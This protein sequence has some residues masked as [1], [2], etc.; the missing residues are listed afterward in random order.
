MKKKKGFTLVELLAVIV[1]LAIILVIAVPQ[2]MDTIDSARSAS[3]ESSAKMVAAQVENQHTVS[4]TLGTNFSSSG[5]CTTAKWAGL[6]DKDYESCTYSID[7]N[8]KASVTLVGKGK[9][10][11]KS[12]CDGTRTSAKVT[13]GECATAESC[14]TFDSSTGTITGYDISCGTDVVIP[15]KIGGVSVTVIGK[16]AFL[17]E[18]ITSVVL[19]DTISEIGI[20]AF[21]SNHITHLTIPSSVTEIRSDAFYGNPLESVNLGNASIIIGNCAFAINY[22]DD[23]SNI[24]VHNIPESYTCVD[25]RPQ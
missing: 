22:E 11:G 9:F 1:I 21:D 5:D 4:Q 19:P 3:L 14:F 15:S 8:G 10:D 13:E 7:S 20:A 18:G 2:I 23:I 6:N 12:I 24:S 17:S 16:F 25:D